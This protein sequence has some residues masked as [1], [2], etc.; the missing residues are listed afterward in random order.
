MYK[1]FKYRLLPDEEQLSQIKMNCGCSRV[2]YNNLL[3]VVVD[4]LKV[5]EPPSVPVVT[6]LY[7]EFPFLKNA[8]SLALANSRLNLNNALSGFWKSRKGTRKGKLGFPKYKSKKFSKSSYTTNNQNNSVRV[9]DSIIRLPK[10][11]FV[12]LK[13]HRPIQGNIKSVTISVSRDDFVEISI[14]CET[15]LSSTK[16]YKSNIDDLKVVGLDMSMSSFFVSSGG[17]KTNFQREYRKSQN[18]RKRLSRKV[19]RK[20]LVSIQKD[21]KT[22]KVPSKNRE[23]AIRK[24]TKFER[25]ISN[26]RKDF[27]HKTSRKLVDNYDVIVLE[28]INL[29]S[30]AQ[31]LRLGKSVHDL[32]FGLFRAFLEYKAKEVDTLVVRVPKYFPS[33]KLCHVCNYKIDTLKLSD[34]VWVC[35][36]CNT[37]HNRDVNASENLKNYFVKE[38]STVG[39]TGINVCGD[40][41]C[42]QRE[43]LVELLSLNQKGDVVKFSTEALSFR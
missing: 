19:S 14:L 2:V 30:M 25:H 42:S 35:T 38:L 22:I 37:K 15:T 41:I 36:S 10:I 32:G 26:K 13:L 20:K 17:E 5:G 33:S 23:K 4:K 11:G 40:S 24:L 1:A 39:T 7:E 6:S 3:A 29:Q 28:D 18:K 43:T 8:D 12:K 34:R 21:G 16:R 27:A 9:K 31:S